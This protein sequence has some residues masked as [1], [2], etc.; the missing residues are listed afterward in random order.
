MSFAWRL[1]ALLWLTALLNYLDRQ[2]IFSVFPLLE[3]ELQL[4]NVQLGLLGTAFLWVYGLLSPV[5][6]YVADRFGKRRTILFSLLVWSG[7][8]WINGHAHSFAHL[9]WARGLMGISEACFLPAALAWI[10]EYHGDRTRSL[11]T[12]LFM[13]G[14]YVGIVAGGA[15][16]GWM[17][18]RFGWR[19]AFVALGVFGIGYTAILWL[20]TRGRPAAA[21]AVQQAPLLDSLR[22]VFRLRGFLV[23]TAVFA[24]VSTANWVAY[25][26][27]PMHLY[28]RLHMTLADAGFTATFYVQAGGF[29]G[30]LLGG[31]LSDRWIGRSPR[32][33]VWTQAL[34]LAAAAPFLFVAGGVSSWPWLLA[35]LMVFGVGRGTFDSN[36]MP[37]LCQ[38]ARPS[39]RA[40]G[41][42]VFNCAGCIAG[43]LM[44][45]AA[46]WVKTRLGLSA[47]F[48]FAALMWGVSAVALARLPL[49]P[50]AWERCVTLKVRKDEA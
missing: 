29:A 49:Q 48:Q 11:A 16:A 19:V 1:V 40:T 14:N 25:T 21:S 42:G 26:W 34:G 23:L 46:G 33:R 31:A 50:A 28:E 10:S 7:V 4:D 13:T 32:G 8:T 43:G 17:G 24:A 47:A 3:K 9:L 30:I 35:S 45:V 2:M 15:G 12:G 18:D 36:A 20:L 22:E 6:G 41:Y 39:L 44:T 5:A 37:V 38:I 27:L